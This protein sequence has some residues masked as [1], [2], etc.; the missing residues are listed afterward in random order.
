MSAPWAAGLLAP[1]Y[2]WFRSPKANR[3]IVLTAV[4]DLDRVDLAIG[5]LATGQVRR[6][7]LA[8]DGFLDSA[9]PSADGRA[10]FV[11]DDG[12]VGTEMGHVVRR[13]VDPSTGTLGP[14]LDLTPDRPAYALRGADVSA[15]GRW[16]VLDAVSDAGYE[17]LVVAADGQS[18]VRTLLRT[19]HEAWN[20]RVSADGRLAS[21]DTTDHA[22]RTRRFAITVVEVADGRIVGEL[23]LPGGGVATAVGWSPIAGD[24]RLLARCQPAAGPEQ[25]A[26]FS[27]RTGERQVV[28]VADRGA[29]IEPLDWSPDG[30][31]V[32][33]VVHR[34]SAQTLSRHD[35]VMETSEVLDL[36]SG[37]FV[38]A[39]Q[40]TSGFGAGG[41]VLAAHENGTSPLS[42]LASR[43][44]GEW[45]A[46][47]GDGPTGAGL[48]SV[49]FDS[50]DGTAVQA[51]LAVPD[52]GPT[53]RAVVH[54]HGGPH[55]SAIDE[56]LPAARAWVAAG[57]SFLT[58]N[59]RG[60]TGR[61]A[62]FE[63]QIHGDIG[64]WELEDLAAAHRWL[65]AEGWAGAERIALTGASYGGYL[66]LYALGRQPALWAAGV[67]EVALADWE[68]SYR[69]SSPA[70]RRLE[71]LLFGGPPGAVPDLYRDR[72]PLTH[73]DSVTAPVLLWQG[74]NDTRTPPGQA[75][76]YAD[77]LARRGHPVELTWFDGGHGFGG[78]LEYVEHLQRSAAFVESA[79]AATQ[80][81]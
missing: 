35:L 45:A 24:D 66:V 59:Y 30:R 57:Y 69:D 53:G 61:G 47:L 25:V 67:A 40:R 81:V 19:E 70:I 2:R 15:D 71:E 33:S 14:G 76:A 78:E 6:L 54:C 10:V 48:R 32:L 68:L 62:A 37:S 51:W 21:L 65:V 9:W 11:L 63:E 18:A 49:F 38:S 77:R 36:P 34:L 79:L 42:L 64:H 26:V 5:D 31:F 73:A 52:T 55:V 74:R 12:G 43:G 41:S 20:C 7:G 23:A 8:T 50:S 27:P 46:L 28:A 39:Y 22:P 60:S 16:L 17:L 58:V 56:Y 13:P 80:K 75:Q 29:T 44:A 4:Q 72:S 1:R 3:G